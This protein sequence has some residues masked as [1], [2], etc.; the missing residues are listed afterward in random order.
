MK[1]IKDRALVLRLVAYRE[2]DLIVHFLGESSGKFGALV[3][4]AKKSQ[5]G[6]SYQPGDLL[7]LDY[8][9]QEGR[10]L[11]RVEQASPL[12][13]IHPDRFSYPRFLIHSYLLELS[14][15]ASAEDQA[16][17]ELFALLSQMSAWRWPPAKEVHFLLWAIE[18]MA[19]GLGFGADWGACGLCGRESYRVEADELKL[20]KMRYQL[21]ASGL[22]CAQCSGQEGAFGA[23]GVK[24]LI[25]AQQDDFLDLLPNIPSELLNR[26]CL[27]LNRRLL[28]ALELRPKSLVLLERLLLV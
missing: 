6:F 26:L 20:R 4:G 16:A 3:F 11:V 27:A 2:S 19:L 5:D 22:V 10:D 14:E 12:L 15:K 18:Q 25:L 7:E 1:S 13:L 23:A 21:Q 28:D 9:T 24:A 17:P 8:R